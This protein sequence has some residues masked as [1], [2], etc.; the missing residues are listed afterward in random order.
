[1]QNSELY[2]PINELCWDG[3]NRFRNYCNSIHPEL[4]GNDSMET[5]MKSFSGSYDDWEII[6]KEVSNG[7]YK[8]IYH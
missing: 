3:F 5:V 4:N 1:M 2:R 8:R 6:L 7:T